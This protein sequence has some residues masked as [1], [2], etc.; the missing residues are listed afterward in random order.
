MGDNFRRKARCV[1]LVSQSEGHL[2]ERA[3]SQAKF[4]T[5]CATTPTINVRS[6]GWPEAGAKYLVS[7]VNIA[8]SQ[9]KS[10]GVSRWG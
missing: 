10:A 4:A 3:T 1:R 7:H 9:P 5:S 8:E 6:S 2:R